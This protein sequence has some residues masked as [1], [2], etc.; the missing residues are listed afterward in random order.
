MHARWVCGACA[1][2]RVGTQVGGSVKCWGQNYHG[3]LGYGDKRYRGDDAG[4]M[5]ENLPVVDLLGGGKVTKAFEIYT[6]SAHAC[7]Q[8]VRM[9]VGALVF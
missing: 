9:G 3:Q 1:E 8:L 6:G 5:G 4:E 7:A 2:V